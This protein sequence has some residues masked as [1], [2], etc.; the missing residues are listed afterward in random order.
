M[1]ASTQPKLAAQ[2]TAAMAWWRDAGV[3][4]DFAD[5]PTRWLAAPDDSAEPG[6][7][8]AQSATASAAKA[9]AAAPEPRA[10]IGGPREGWP[11]DLESFAAW[12]L[13]EPA[14]DDG[15]VRERVPPRGA[16]GAELMVV[17]PQPEIGDAESGDAGAPD[18]PALLSGPEGRLLDAIITA[19]GL[20]SDQ[21]YRA[22]VLP[23]HTPLADWPALSAAGIGAVLCHHIALVAP[24]R[25]IVLGNSILP[26]VGH[27]PAQT[28]KVL[29]SFNHE[30]RTIPLLGAFELGAMLGRPKWKAAF[31][32]R[33]LDWT[34]TGIA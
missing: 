5:T 3:D 19:M 33:W 1:D 25:L 18:G 14:L 10:M 12:W 31:W 7:G 24:K 34:G 28:A 29:Q 6:A 23:R 16:A 27:D 13:S 17:V 8:F 20:S 22:A 21:V 30:G 11:Q 32:Q 15:A 4:L 9:A 26:L 2:F